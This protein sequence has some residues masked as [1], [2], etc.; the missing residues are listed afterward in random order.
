MSDFQKASEFLNK[1]KDV[2][3]NNEMIDAALGL[4]SR[5]DKKEAAVSLAKEELLKAVTIALSLTP[6]VSPD[7]SREDKALYGTLIY[8]YSQILN[9]HPN[10][11]DI[12]FKLAQVYQ[13][14]RQ[15]RKAEEELTRALQINSDFTQARISL[16]FMYRDCHRLEDAAREFDLVL[17]KG[18][19]YPTIA[20]ELGLI[21]KRLGK[22]HLALRAF[23][24]ALELDPHF[25]GAKEELEEL[26]A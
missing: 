11:A 4:I 24:K 12:R 15:Y 14:Q 25:G 5:Q 6:F 8:I 3:P 13:N 22:R 2:M 18:L 19:R 7:I 10:Y 23:Q 9:E 20:F 21:Y 26:S 16:G 1:A 17:G